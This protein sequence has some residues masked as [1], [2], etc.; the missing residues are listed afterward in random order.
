MVIQYSA[1]IKMETMD[2][3]A[4]D[5]I[6]HVPEES[7]IRLFVNVLPQIR[8][9]ASKLAIGLGLYITSYVHKQA[10]LTLVHGLLNEDMECSIL[11]MTTW[12]KILTLIMLCKLTQS[13]LNFKKV[14]FR[15]A[16]GKSMIKFYIV[17][18]LG[19]NLANSEPCPILRLL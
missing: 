4:S 3:L 17:N 14:M 13:L 18:A 1:M 6:S 10:A 19:Q 2:Q 8:N 16:K 11:T 9:I 15:H 7:N 12:G 5:L